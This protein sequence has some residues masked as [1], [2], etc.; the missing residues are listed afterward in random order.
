MNNKWSEA[1]KAFI[2]ENAHRL[3]DSEIAEHLTARSGRKITLQGVRKQRQKLG[4]KKE[5]GR[6]RCGVVNVGGN[7]DNDIATHKI[8]QLTDS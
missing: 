4:I 5:A 8:H 6:G 3:K 7:T 2:K 1:E